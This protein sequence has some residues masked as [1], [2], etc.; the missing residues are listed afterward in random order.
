MKAPCSFFYIILGGRG[1]R[2]S[3]CSSPSP[4]PSLHPHSLCVYLFCFPRLLCVLSRWITTLRL[5]VPRRAPIYVYSSVRTRISTSP[6][7]A[8]F[9]LSRLARSGL[10]E[11][12]APIPPCYLQRTPDFLPIEFLVIG[13][14]IAGL[15]AAIALTRV[16][17]QVTVIDWNDPFK[18]VR[19]P[20]SCLRVPSHCANYGRAGRQITTQASGYRPIRPRCTIDG[21]WSS[22]YGR[23][24]SSP[25]ERCSRRVRAPPFARFASR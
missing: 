6:W 9:H 15:S 17:H 25:R 20:C 3:S 19:L 2:T 7:C 14:S 4:P 21:G 22:A 12:P 24:R 18:P 23:P 10:T 13:G 1:S 11:A 16:G 5:L 8:P